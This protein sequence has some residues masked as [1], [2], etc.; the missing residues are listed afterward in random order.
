MKKLLLLSAIILLTSCD[1]GEIPH[2]PIIDNK[3]PTTPTASPTPTDP[4]IPTDP[5]LPEWT[6]MPDQ[7]FEKALIKQ[8]YDDVVDG[9]VLTSNI[10]GINKIYLEHAN[11][12][13]TKG[14]ENFIS[15]EFLSFW[16]NPFTSIDVSHNVKLKIFGISECPVSTIDLSK[17]IELEEIAFQHNTVGVNDPNYPFGRTVGLT[18]LDL[19]H[20]VKLKRIYL[21]MNRLKSLDVSMLPELTDLWLGNSDANEPTNVGN[22]IKTIDISK[23][24]RLD[25]IHVS[26]LGLMDLNIKNT[27]NNGIPRRFTVNHNPDLLEIKVKSIE[28]IKKALW[29][30]PTY[31]WNNTTYWVIDSWVKY[32]E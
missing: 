23:N 13:N 30:A 8:G 26:D 10:S 11:I 20:N 24:F 32:I 2:Y 19:S 1:P 21:M 18:S 31:W 22:K 28:A 7:N 5:M 29:K 17:N 27:P 12:E 6:D 9:K 14:I 16:D 4:T 15:L 25:N 3:V